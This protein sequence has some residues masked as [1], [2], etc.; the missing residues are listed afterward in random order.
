MKFLG[1]EL[2]Q[3]LCDLPT[4]PWT[5][6]WVKNCYSIASVPLSLSVSFS[7][8]DQVKVKGNPESHFE[9]GTEERTP[10][11]G[12]NFKKDTREKETLGGSP[13]PKA[14]LRGNTTLTQMGK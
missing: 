1:V 9:A 6:T 13:I 12:E 4:Q 2:R 3:L 14:A 10:R 8:L 5:V 11:N 7:L